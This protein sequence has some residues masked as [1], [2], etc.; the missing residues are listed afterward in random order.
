MAALRPSDFLPD[1][2]FSGENVSHEKAISHW[3]L[4]CDYLQIHGLDE[5][6]HDHMPLVTV[7]FRLTLTGEARLWAEGKAFA[8]LEVMRDAFIRR[9][10]PTHSDFAN[11]KY[12]D[13][14]KYK[15][16]ETAEQFLQKINIAAQRINYNEDQVR[17]KFLHSLPEDCQRAVVMAAA[18]D[19]DAEELA[20]IAQKY[21]DL[22]PNTTVT[23]QVS[24]PD[25]VHASSEIKTLKEEVKS[26]EQGMQNLQVQ[27]ARPT[28]SP[29]PR[30]PG[31]RR[32][33][34]RDHP[35]DRR[36][37][38]QSPSRPRDNNSRTPSRERY[39]QDAR[40]IRCHF[41][42]KYGH[43]WR[44]CFHYLRMAHQQQSGASNVQGSSSNRPPW[45]SVPR[46]QNQSLYQHS[47]SPQRQG[48]DWYP[49]SSYQNDQNF[50]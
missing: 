22:L 5:P 10:S 35:H 29:S 34:D 19:H 38:S 12:F 27:F 30:S 45:E 46:Q 39:R 48:N 47:Q 3:Y 44:Q 33:R 18:P 16:G 36:Q 40:A 9:F 37:R 8:N 2:K 1:P 42:S 31:P 4:F 43:R 7:R 6:D 15:T 13:D 26:L 24:F 25:Q 50:Q 41:C 49:M 14:L 28:R 17:N 21:L 11:V 32:H 20:N 23:K